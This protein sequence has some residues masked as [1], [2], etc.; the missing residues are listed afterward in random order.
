MVEEPNLYIVIY[1]VKY[2]RTAD[3]GYVDVLKA[4]AIVDRTSTEANG[5]AYV[6]LGSL[7]LG[8]WMPNGKAGWVPT[9]ALEKY[10]PPAPPTTDPTTD[11]N[12]IMVHYVN[13]VETERFQKVI[14]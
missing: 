6:K 3:G 1:D 13:G 11:P 10:T 8:L 12:D 5:K 7:V 4:D 2:F 9:M 14:S